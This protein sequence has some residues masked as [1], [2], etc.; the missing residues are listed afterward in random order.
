MEHFTKNCILIKI[1]HA[2][3]QLSFRHFFFQPRS[4][5]DATNP[6]A[7]GCQGCSTDLSCADLK[8]LENGRLE[9]PFSSL[10]PNRL[11]LPSSHWIRNWTELARRNASFLSGSVVSIK[12][13][14]DVEQGAKQGDGLVTQTGLKTSSHRGTCTSCLLW[15]LCSGGVVLCTWSL[16][17]ESAARLKILMMRTG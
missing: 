1:M 3:L 14:C 12:Q 17:L 15:V 11:G 5:C 7:P 16:L 4:L 6:A 8:W 13:R 9:L 2:F 10:A